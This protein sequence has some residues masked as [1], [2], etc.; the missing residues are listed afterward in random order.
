[1]PAKHFTKVT[2]LLISIFAP[3][4]S[5]ASMVSHRGR[6]CI[7]SALTILDSGLTS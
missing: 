3:I 6:N 1:M 2:T 7:S 5:S 4:M